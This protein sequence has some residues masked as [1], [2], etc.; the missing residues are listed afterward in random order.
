MESPGTPGTRDQRGTPIQVG[1]RPSS[2]DPATR[3]TACW[4]EARR[5][6]GIWDAVLERWASA[7]TFENERVA[8]AVAAGMDSRYEPAAPSRPARP[9]APPTLKP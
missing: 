1:Q 6:Y 8:A 2:A 9:L 7:P 5:G 3:F 4:N